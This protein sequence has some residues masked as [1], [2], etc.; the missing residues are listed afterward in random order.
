M[1][2]KKWRYNFLILNQESVKKLYQKL[3][4]DRLEMKNFDVMEH[5]YQCIED[6]M[7]KPKKFFVNMNQTNGRTQSIHARK[8]KSIQ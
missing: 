5:N 8:D 4:D 1:D 7:Q 6:T 2:A 3:L